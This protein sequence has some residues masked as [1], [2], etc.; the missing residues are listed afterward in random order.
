MPPARLLMTV[1]RGGFDKVIFA[2]GAATIDESDAP[3]IAVCHLIATQ[4]NRMVAD[5]VAVHPLVV[6]AE[7][8]PVRIERDSRHHFPQVFA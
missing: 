7:R 6:F 8:Y 4:V 1:V 3:H 2:R 5:K